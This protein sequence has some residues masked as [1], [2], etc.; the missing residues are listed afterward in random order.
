MQLDIFFRIVGKIGNR[1]ENEVAQDSVV[2]AENLNN[3]E[4]I[5]I[6][7][8]PGE[9]HRIEDAAENEVIIQDSEILN[10]IVAND[11]RIVGRLW[12][13]QEQEDDIEEVEEHG[14]FTSV[15]TKSRKKNLK[16]KGSHQRVHFTR[17]GGH[18]KSV[19]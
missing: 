19:Q 14:V 18:S 5:Q 16:K 4:Y 13:D 9:H 8:I 15:L 2:R 17:R 6:R 7:E 1:K 3:M 12:A 10:P 11:M